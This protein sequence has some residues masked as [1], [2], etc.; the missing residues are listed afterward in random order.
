MNFHQLYIDG[1]WV[2]AGGTA[3]LPVTDSF[4]EAI[5]AHY[6]AAS[7]TD[8]DTAVRA[9][10]R[11]FEG[12]AATPVAQRIDAVRRVAG[13]LQE[14]SA[15]IG[16]VISREVGMPAK[17]AAR[18][19]AAAPIAAWTMYADLAADVEWQRRVGHSLV[20]QLPVGVV[21]CITP[22]NYPLHQVTGK[23]APA[24][25]AGCTVVLKP[26]ELAP[27]SAFLLAEAIDQAGL[28]P[29]VFNLVHGT[30]P[31][32]GEAL[33]RHPGVDMV[34]FTGSTAAGR[35]IAAQA[36]ADIKRVSLELGGKSAALLLP[37]ADLAAAVKAT[38]AGCFL[39]AGQTCSATTRLLVPRADMAA[40]IEL[41]RA[42]LAA[43]R[44]GDPADAAT[45]L[46]P[47]ISKAQQRK[48]LAL[49]EAAMTGGAEALTP[50]AV[51]PPTG[52]FVPPTVLLGVRP[53]MAIA[54]EEVFGPVLAVISY[55][56]VDEAVAIANG[57]DY[58]LAGS[59]WAATARQALSVAR[60]L[61]TGQL[62][63]NGAPFNPAAPFGGF[64]RSGLGRENGR[65]GIEEFIEPMA[66]Q[67]PADHFDAPEEQP[68]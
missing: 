52:F 32:V 45:R 27:S 10:Q 41:L 38:L 14:R 22:W 1:A 20:Q 37:G 67:L 8:V 18:I 56:G 68:A 30:G 59:V 48:V 16:A 17:L 31:E 36:G 63:I 25:L 42:G 65:Y 5:F 44:M 55:D 15:A 64:K 9:A 50:E 39:N 51:P 46:G 43:W 3:D 13:A 61:R 47:L 24:L 62:D 66:I 7:T 21:G 58:G 19:Q 28:P 29:G 54:R 35:R 34:S 60:R 40:V 49:I 23:V 4:S 2:P 57:T 53:D 11:A 6:R 12:W 33:V 26:S